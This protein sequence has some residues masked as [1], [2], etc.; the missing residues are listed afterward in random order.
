VGKPRHIRNFVVLIV[1]LAGSIYCAASFQNSD[2]VQFFFVV[3]AGIFSPAIIV[4]VYK[5][6]FGF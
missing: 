3:L 2:H 1:S 6:L 4:A 5:A